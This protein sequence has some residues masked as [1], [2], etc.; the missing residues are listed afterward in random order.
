MWPCPTS[1]DQMPPAKSFCRPPLI[2]GHA[3]D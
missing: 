3:G 2:V 1:S